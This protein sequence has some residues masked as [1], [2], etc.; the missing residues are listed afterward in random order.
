MME[1][2]NG[3][4]SVL[5]WERITLSLGRDQTGRDVLLLTRS[6]ARHGVA[7]LHA[8]GRRTGRA[9]RRT[10]HGRSSAPTRSPRRTA[11]GSA[12]GHQ[13]SE[14]VLMRVAY[15]RSSI[16]VPAGIAAALEHELHAHGMPSSGSGRR[17]PHYIASMTYPAASVALL[18]GL[19]ESTGLVI[20]AAT[21][22]SE[23]MIQ[24][25]R[26]DSPGRCQRRARGDDRPT[27]G[28]VRRDRRRRPR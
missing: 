19:R 9:V 22:R 13:P 11:S 10:P 3:L 27:R 16:D 6:R 14:D 18:D 20:D 21:L 12:L 5:N 4:N 28:D 2:R 8:G 15:L 25:R 17:C 7:P 26:L 24:G 23:V 1:L